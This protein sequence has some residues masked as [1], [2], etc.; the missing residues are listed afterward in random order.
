MA[1]GM[2]RPMLPSR[3]TVVNVEKDVSTR[4][5]NVQ[6][7]LRHRESFLKVPASIRV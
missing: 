7:T 6:G 4:S 1:K 3:M 2:T 5:M